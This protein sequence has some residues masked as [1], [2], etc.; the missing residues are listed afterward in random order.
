MRIELLNQSKYRH[1]ARPGDDV[2]LVLPGVVFGVFDGATDPR[3]T[4]VE[5][6]AAGR[7]A[8][9]TVSA[10]MAA[11]VADPAARL[12]P[13][14]EI[15]GGLAA[16]LKART[17]PLDLPIPPSTTVSVVL[18]CGDAWRFL[19]LGDTGI[20]LNGTEVLR[21]NKVIDTVSTEARVRVFRLLGAR[22][23][24]GDATEYATRRVVML[25]LDSAVSES[26][27]SPREADKIIVE[28]VATTGLAR[29]GAE[30]ETFLRG[31]IQ[32]QF[33]HGNGRGF[34]AFDTLN[35]TETGLGSVIDTVRPKAEVTS[36]E[37][38]T[39]GYPDIPEEVSPAA[40]E[41]AFHEAERRDYHKTGAFAAV[42]GST[43]TEFFDDRTVLI[44]SDMLEH[45]DSAP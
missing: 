30:V 37:V 24:D 5:G 29:H 16:T 19:V 21:H 32:T 27:L 17:D 43:K 34:L 33:H 23:G 2:P 7:L 15:I 14:S 44:L 22:I 26:V 6:M 45:A 18:D 11:I 31:G 35:G 41:D 40:W 13:A 20:R 42:K 3:G 10:R 39:D 1:G 28:T 12:R 9:Q 4:R 38:F 8:A 36:V 25:G